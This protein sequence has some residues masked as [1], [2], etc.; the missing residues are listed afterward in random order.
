M[1]NSQRRWL[2]AAYAVEDPTIRVHQQFPLSTVYDATALVRAT[3]A[4]DVTAKITFRFYDADGVQVGTCRTDTVRI[5]P[6]VPR[7]VECFTYW[8]TI[9]VQSPQPI[10]VRADAAPWLPR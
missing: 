3:T 9:D 8:P 6:E 7:R 1:T 10:T 5:Q 2:P 4:R